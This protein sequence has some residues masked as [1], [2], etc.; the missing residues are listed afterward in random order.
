MD[1]ILAAITRYCQYQPRS[2]KE[3]RNKLYE[4]GC[5][6]ASVEDYLAK[7][8]AA[9]FLNEENY[10][11]AIA[12]GK[13]RIKQWGRNKIIQALRQQQVSDYCIKKGLAE[14][15]GDEYEA[16]LQKLG[17]RKWQELKA[18]RSPNAKK[19]KLQRYLLQKGY[20]GDLVR[21]LIKLLAAGTIK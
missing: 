12:R 1:A 3:V 10:A 15:D 13:F 2:H 11:R 5:T 21:D 18:E 20:E 16:T 7:V 17:L 19:A 6:S 8:I 9:G 14:I 4:L